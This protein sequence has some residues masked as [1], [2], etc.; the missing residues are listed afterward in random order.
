MATDTTTRNETM[1]S[2][3]RVLA[4]I[5]LNV[6]APLLERVAQQRLNL[7]D[8]G[9]AQTLESLHGFLGQGQFTLDG[10]FQ[11]GAGDQHTV[12]F[13]GTFIN[14]IDSLVSVSPLY[15]IVL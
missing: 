10:F 15:R 13:V 8:G 1:T 2:R 3:E 5:V 4:A 6:V 9:F 12:D 14:P 7:I 11:D